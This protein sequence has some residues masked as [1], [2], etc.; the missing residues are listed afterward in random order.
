M[1]QPSESRPAARSVANAFRLDGEI[2]LITGG[3]TGL[4]LAMAKAMAASGAR[5]VIAGRRE[6]PLR[7]AVA[8]IGENATYVAHDIADASKARD[9]IDAAASRAGGVPTILV[10]NAGIHL[11][12]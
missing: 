10:N 4:G 8:T 3:G 6:Q 11:K 2:A 5:V 1:S 7:D 12:K 9:L